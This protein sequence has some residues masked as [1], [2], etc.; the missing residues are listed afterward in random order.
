MNNKNGDKK[1]GNTNTLTILTFYQKILHENMLKIEITLMIN[2]LCISQEK[3]PKITHIITA[4]IIDAIYTIFSTIFLSYKHHLI[5]I[6]TI[7]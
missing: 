1:D 3:C 2:R 7:S 4:Y 5:I 6:T